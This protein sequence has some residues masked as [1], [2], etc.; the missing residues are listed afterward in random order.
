VS[1]RIRPLASGAAAVLA[2]ALIA[3]GCGD[4]DES[5][6]TTDT[7]AEESVEQTVDSAVDS[8]TDAAQGLDGAAAS[9][10]EAAC[11]QIG[12]AFKQDLSAA[13]DD[14][15]KAISEAAKTCKQEV[16]KL[17]SGGAQDTLS[18]L[19]ESIEGAGNGG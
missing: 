1:N 10:A 7:S 8:C 15:D 2:V 6:T 4:D 13:G 16:N 12:D 14:V 11:K 17:P 9:A 3:A 19:C 5:T 18:S